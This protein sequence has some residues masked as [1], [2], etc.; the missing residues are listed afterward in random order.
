MWWGPGLCGYT[1]H[2]AQAG[3][4]RLADALET[5][6]PGHPRIPPSGLRRALREVGEA[7]TMTWRE[8]RENST[9]RASRCSGR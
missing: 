8:A 5:C 9:P 2:I 7:E 4:Y 1:P 6:F 3:R